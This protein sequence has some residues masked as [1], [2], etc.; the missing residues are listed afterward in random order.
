MPQQKKNI[1]KSTDFIHITHNTVVYLFRQ[2]H[3]V[4]LTTIKLFKII[5]VYYLL[6]MHCG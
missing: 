1:V 6:F 5:S 3:Q 2:E 4:I